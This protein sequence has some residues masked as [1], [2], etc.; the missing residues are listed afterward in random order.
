[1]RGK[2]KTENQLINELG[3]M[4]QRIIELEASEAERKWMEQVVQRSTEFIDTVLN[5]ITDSISI[6]DTHDFKVIGANSTL[7]ETLKVNEKEVIGKTCYELTHRKSEPCGSPDVTCPLLETVKTGRP[8]SAEHV[9]YDKDGNT[10]DVE[11]STYPVTNEQGRVYQAVHVTRD[12]TERKQA[13]QELAYMATHDSLTKLPNRMLFNDR[14]NLELAHAHRNQKRLAVMLL[15]LDQ[16][17]D[18]NDTLGH[19]VGDQLLRAVGDRLTRLVRKSD[20]VARMGGDEFLLLLPEVAWV[21]DT[22][23]IAQKVLEAFGEPFV[24]D[25]HELHITTSIGIAIFPNDGEDADTLVKNA[26]IAMYSA[27][28]R[29]RN[30]YQR[31]TAAMK[32]KALQ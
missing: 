15:D 21:E 5:S 14:L 13:E 24:F 30:N 29:G 12:I 1:M 28:E 4:R 9:H 25:A 32:S 22:A 26:D 10:I 7:L 3:K 11:I 27:K 16:F 31:W 23:K 2:D 6:I 8:S 17:K 20:T 18:V 19:S